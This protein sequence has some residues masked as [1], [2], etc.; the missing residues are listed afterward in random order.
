MTNTN[1]PAKNLY[2]NDGFKVVD[3]FK[4]TYN[5]ISVFANKMQRG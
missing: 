4:T 1:I 3:E 5:G 2:S